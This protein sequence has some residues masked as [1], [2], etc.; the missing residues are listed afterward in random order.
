MSKEH[1]HKLYPSW[2]K[3]I[4]KKLRYWLVTHRPTPFLS[5]KSCLSCKIVWNARLFS[6][7]PLCGRGPKSVWVVVQEDIVK[8]IY[9]DP[10]KAKWTKRHLDS[11]S[12]NNEKS[13]IQAWSIE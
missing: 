7:C 11:E 10:D 8:G 1:N 6:A 12:E 2:W 4:V 3:V 9:D 13:E 5:R